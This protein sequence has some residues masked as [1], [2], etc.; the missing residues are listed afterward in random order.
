MKPIVGLSK[1]QY[2]GYQIPVEYVTWEH[3]RVEIEALGD[4]LDIRLVPARFEYPKMKSFVMELFPPYY[5]NAEA[6]GVFDG[7]KPIAMM[8][9]NEET[10]NKRLRVTELWVADEWRHKGYGSALLQHAKQLAQQK[11]CRMVILETQ[12]CNTAAIN[13]YRKNGFR[14]IGLDTTCYQNDDVERGEVRLEL[15]CKI[16]GDG[17]D[18]PR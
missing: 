5:E 1:D 10:W 17:A 4:S 8:E 12:T 13:L 18:D 6:Y 14:V 3:V 16:E 15:G 7:E 9:L 11:G 2:L